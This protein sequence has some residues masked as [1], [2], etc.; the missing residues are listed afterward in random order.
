MANR[1]HESPP[2][3]ALPLAT[4]TP[5]WVNMTERL[6][7]TD[8][9]LTLDT[10]VVRC[11]QRD[12]GL[13]DVV[14]SATLFHPQ[15]GGQLSD[16]GTI[17]GVDVVKVAALDDAI[18]HVC[19]RAVP[20]GTVR[21]EVCAAT[22][23]LHARLHSAGHL[24]GCSGEALGW[25]A[26]KGHHWP[27]EARV[28]FEGARD[29]R[30]FDAQ[31]IEALANAHVSADLPRRTSMQGTMRTIGFGDLPAHGCGGTHVASSSAVGRIRILKVKE[32]KGQV[33]V[34]YDLEGA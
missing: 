19:D 3:N 30:V 24:I 31:E 1:N 17:A 18:V 9:R 22:R 15:G 20:V 23:A 27:G 12:D 14:L 26:V 33:S 29:A 25:H 4:L 34:Y 2:A 6:Y 28:V 10:S 7:M 8:D 16:R 13:F 11:T 21:V 5:P 32:K